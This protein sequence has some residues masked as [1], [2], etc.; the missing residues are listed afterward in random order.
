MPADPEPIERAGAVILDQHVGITNER[1]QPFPIIRLLQ[2]KGHTLLVAYTNPPP[3]RQPI[4]LQSELASG[5]AAVRPFDLDD[6]GTEI[7]KKAAAERPGDDIAEFDD[8]Q[9]FER[10]AVSASLICAHCAAMPLRR[11][12]STTSRASGSMA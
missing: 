4:D 2:I 7:G 11:P 10:K 5:I 1:H 3:H 9:A 8:P 6:L 12:S